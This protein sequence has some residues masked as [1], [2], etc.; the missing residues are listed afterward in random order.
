MNPHLI[1]N[2]L[3]SIRSM[4]YKNE[5]DPAIDLLTSLAGLIRTTFE[6]AEKDFISLSAEISFLTRYLEIEKIRFGDKFTFNLV[7]SEKLNTSEIMVPP[8]LLQPFIENAVNHGLM[9]RRQGGILKLELVSDG[10]TLKCMIE[11]NGVGREKAR[12]IES[13]AITSHTSASDK[14]TQERILLFNKLFS[15]EVF[16]IE[17]IDLESENKHP[18]GTRVIIQLPAMDITGWQAILKR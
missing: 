1:A 17:T 9:H 11:D 7:V 6:N 15:S 4:L 12:E 8:M 13:H 3:T 14:I 5:T 10:I 18:A 2:A 16:I